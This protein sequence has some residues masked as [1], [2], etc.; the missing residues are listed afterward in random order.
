MGWKTA[1]ALVQ[2]LGHRCHMN[3]Y[4][5]WFCDK[6]ID[7]CDGGA[8]MISVGNLWR[9]DAGSRSEDDPWQTIYAH[10]TCAQ[11]RLAGATMSIEPYIFGQDE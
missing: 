7:R 6:G 1:V 4:Q 8:V 3:E 9:W 10:A 2:M 11:K 5:C